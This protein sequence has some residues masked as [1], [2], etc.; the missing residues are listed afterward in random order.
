MSFFKQMEDTGRTSQGSGNENN[1]QPQ[2]TVSME[3]FMMMKTQLM[4]QMAQTI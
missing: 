3:Q 2:P 4:Q 1:P